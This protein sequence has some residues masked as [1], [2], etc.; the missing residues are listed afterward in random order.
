MFKCANLTTGQFVV[1][2]FFSV[3]PWHFKIL[4]LCIS[5]PMPLSVSITR[6]DTYKSRCSVVM[7]DG[8]VETHE[9]TVCASG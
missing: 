7:G 8:D 2:F 6:V 1:G 5:M 9:F 3:I 4:P